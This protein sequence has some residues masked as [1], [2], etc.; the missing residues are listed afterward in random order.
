MERIDA[1]ANFLELLPAVVL[2]F[3]AISHPSLH[4]EL[5]TDWNDGETITKANGFLYQL[6]SSTFLIVFH[7]LLKV[8]QVLRE[9]TIKLQMQAMDVL[10]AYNS[11]EGALST[12]KVMRQESDVRFRKIFDEAT[13]LGKQLHGGTFELTIP[14]ICGRQSHRNNPSVSNPEDYFRIT[15]YDEVTTKS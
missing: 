5:G 1:Y 12:I 14:R 15:M 9:L 10:H 2:A 3:Q 4:C 11:V 13:K 8:L 7:I 6:Q